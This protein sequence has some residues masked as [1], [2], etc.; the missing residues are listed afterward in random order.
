MKHTLK[1]NTN[2]VVKLDKLII[3]VNPGLG[4]SFMDS[5]MRWDILGISFCHGYSKHWCIYTYMYMF[6]LTIVN[7]AK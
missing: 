4:M 7:N 3:I 2:R 5:W 6:S 1:H